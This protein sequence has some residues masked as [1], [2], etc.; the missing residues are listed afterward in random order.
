[1]NKTKTKALAALVAV[2]ASAFAVLVPA[3]SASAGSNSARW[4]KSLAGR[5]GTV[6]TAVLLPPTENNQY[7]YN[8]GGQID[9]DIAGIQVFGAD[10]VP[11]FIENGEPVP[12]PG[13]ETEAKSGVIVNMK[14]NHFVYGS[15]FTTNP[16]FDPANPVWDGESYDKVQRGG[17]VLISREL[18]VFIQYIEICTK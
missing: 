15:R 16:F 2:I 18:L 1:M 3:T 9:P 10:A 14:H 6:L 11:V 4:C 12:G 13:L 17:D 7:S 5:N 8:I